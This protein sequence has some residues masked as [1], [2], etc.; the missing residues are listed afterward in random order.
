MAAES[1]AAPPKA[2]DGKQ[3]NDT[4]QVESTI[5][6]GQQHHNDN[7]TEQARDESSDGKLQNQTTASSATNA[8]E[9]KDDNTSS[10]P[11]ESNAGSATPTSES[12]NKTGTDKSTD[13]PEGNRVKSSMPISKSKITA[14]NTSTAQARSSSMCSN[15]A[16]YTAEAIKAH[17]INVKQHVMKIDVTFTPTAKNGF[18]NTTITKAMEEFYKICKAHDEEF[19]ILPWNPEKTGDSPISTWQQMPNEKETMEAYGFNI[20]ATVT[21]IALSLVI[22]TSKSYDKMF[23]DR[24]KRKNETESVYNKL[25]N[26]NI[27]VKKNDLATMGKTTLIGWIGYAHPTLTNYLNLLRDL[28]KLLGTKDVTLVYYLAKLWDESANRVGSSTIAYSIGVPEDIAHQI[29]QELINRWVGL[30]KGDYDDLFDERSNLKKFYFVPF[31]KMFLTYDMRKKLYVD[32]NNFR[33]LYKGIMLNKTKSVDVR[34]QLEKNEM[35]TLGLPA[36]MGHQKTTIREIIGT[37]QAQSEEGTPVVWAIE[38][39]NK[40]RQ[41]LIVKMNAIEIVRKEAV[42]L[43]DV[44]KRRSNEEFIRIM[45]DEMA[46]VDGYDTMTK[47]ALEYEGMLEE[48]ILLID[49]SDAATKQ[50]ISTKQ[51]IPPRKVRP[52]PYNPYQKLKTKGTKPKYSEVAKS[53]NPPKKKRSDTPTS[54]SVSSNSLSSLTKSTDTGK[55]QGHKI[56]STNLSKIPPGVQPTAIVQR[57]VVPPEEQQIVQYTPTEQLLM[58]RI[59]K[60]DDELRQ[61]REEAEKRFAKLTTSVEETSIQLEEANKKVTKKIDSTIAAKLAPQ[62]EKLES[63]SMSINNLKAS[64]DKDKEE[65]ENKIE[66]ATANSEEMNNNIKTMMNWMFSQP[67]PGGNVYGKGFMGSNFSVNS[68]ITQSTQNSTQVPMSPDLTKKSDYVSDAGGLL[69]EDFYNEMDSKN[70]TTAMA[71]TATTPERHRLDGNGT[72]QVLWS[73]NK[74]KNVEES[75]VAEEEGISPTAD[76]KATARAQK[77]LRQQAQKVNNNEQVEVKQEL[78]NDAQAAVAT[79][80]LDTPQKQSSDEA[81]WT[82]I[83]RNNTPS[84]RRGSKATTSRT[85]EK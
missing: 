49:Q 41:V 73:S 80:S 14:P 33:F 19:Q 52:A 18:A 68:L 20:H 81:K 28:Q 56:P 45:G 44:L 30:K 69:T 51:L 62:S 47:A 70:S 83:G 25:N 9:N 17:F 13:E 67:P 61:M 77:R 75:N 72:R 82:V 35:K 85:R 74:K 71:E 10:T 53:N 12:S 78:I 66:K 21:R 48:T 8:V 27:N 34:F 58:D 22:S 40:T 3:T 16:R 1:N 57:K 31:N 46:N 76:Q 26:R 65:L 24:V 6:D 38:A 4:T 50:A 55:Q 11:N 79:G 60:Q 64:R 43:Y 15:Q 84:N 32:H 29:S 36:E 59:Q 2:E 5:T 39:V 54:I 42:A 23:K 37:W 63:I 7:I